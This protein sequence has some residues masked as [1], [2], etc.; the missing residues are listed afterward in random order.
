MTVPVT[1][2]FMLA[3]LVITAILKL[4]VLVPTLAGLPWRPA[5]HERIRKALSMAGVRPGELV[6]DLG[7]GD[8]RVL[9]VAAS[10]FQAR[11][12]GIEISPLHRLVS[13]ALAGLNKTRGRVEVRNGD[14]YKAELSGADVVY[15]Y[16]T[17]KQVGRLKPHLE[18]QLRRDARV[19]TISFDLDG[20][21]P[22]AVDRD[23]LIFLYEMPPVP[24]NLTTYLSKNE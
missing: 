20:W 14:F 5:E 2:F 22:Q 12:V 23:E 10:E 16:M 19:V 21:E 1:V 24:G 13:R 7:S 3:G 18:S 9:L 15:A 17:S 11:A 8:G 4:W 6:Y